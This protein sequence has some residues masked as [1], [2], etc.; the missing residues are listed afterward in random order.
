M[1]SASRFLIAQTWPCP[2]QEC[3]TGEDAQRCVCD[4]HKLVEP[5]VADVHPNPNPSTENPGGMVRHGR[6]DKRQV[7]KLNY[8]SF[9]VAATD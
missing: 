1:P 9:L 6:S 5:P 8:G 2:T 4:A 3:L 7:C